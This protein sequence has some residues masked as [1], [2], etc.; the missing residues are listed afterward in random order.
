MKNGSN[1]RPM[2]F[3]CSKNYLITIEVKYKIW[4]VE[5]KKCNPRQREPNKAWDMCRRE[6]KF[7]R[8]RR[9]SNARNCIICCPNAEKRIPSV[10]DWLVRRCSVVL[11]SIDTTMLKMYY[12]VEFSLCVCRRR[13]ERKTENKKSRRFAIG[14]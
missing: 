14:E 5:K 13:R 1:F 8:Q 4:S 3:N 6:S 11:S 7:I 10:L 9:N 12:F 2:I